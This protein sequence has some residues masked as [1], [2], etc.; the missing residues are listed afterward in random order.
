MKLNEI[1]DNEGSTHSRKRLGRGIGSGKGKTG[2]RG[3]KGQKSRTGVSLAGFEGGQMPLQR[4][5]PK[6]GFSSLT[7]EFVAEI[8]LDE[9]DRLEATEITLDVL[10][11]VGLV[12]SL[13]QRAKVILS[14]KISRKVALNGVHATKGA[15]AALE[16]A[17]GS[18]ADIVVKPVL[19]KLPAKTK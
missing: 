11:A 6:R 12:G 13:T 3:V 18:V 17:G 8:R 4:R 16:A 10:K 19:R 1:T 2:G 15:K 9:L 14:G 5:L 7:R